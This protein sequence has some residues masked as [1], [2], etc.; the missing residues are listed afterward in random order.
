MSLR[1]SAEA[2]RGERSF[3]GLTFTTLVRATPHRVA[4]RRNRQV[5]KPTTHF[6][7]QPFPLLFTRARETVSVSGES[8]CC[9]DLAEARHALSMAP[10]TLSGRP[11]F[12]SIKCRKRAVS[13]CG[14]D[15]REGVREGF[16]D[17]R[18]AGRFRRRGACQGGGPAQLAGTR[19]A[20]APE[21]SALKAFIVVNRQTRKVLAEFETREE[22]EAFRDGLISARA[23]GKT[24]LS[25]RST[26]GGRNDEEAGA[27]HRAE[28]RGHTAHP[29]RR[30][31]RRGPRSA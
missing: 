11:L 4:L 6:L 25:I 10:I 30:K 24:P 8:T 15:G 9:R 16:R 5:S 17:H 19:A 28:K 13:P 21:L 7:V 22:A 2:V 31:Q 29:L 12:V 3:C 18:H 1:A 26:L 20:L 23:T 14:F 27:A